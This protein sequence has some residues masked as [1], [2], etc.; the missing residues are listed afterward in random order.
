MNVYRNLSPE[1]VILQ[2]FHRITR[3]GECAG[4]HETFF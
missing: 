1:T 4:E 2:E 3:K